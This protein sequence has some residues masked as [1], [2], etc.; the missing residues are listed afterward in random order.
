VSIQK[1]LNYA[2]DSELVNH[3]LQLLAQRQRQLET[4][5]GQLSEAHQRVT[6]E[7][8][9]LKQ[10]AV[11][12]LPTPVSMSTTEARIG[13]FIVN[14]EGIATDTTTG[15][16]WCRF[17]LGQQW[18]NH[19]AQGNPQKMNWHEAMQQINLLNASATPCCGYSDWRLPTRSEMQPMIKGLGANQLK[20][21]FNDHVKRTCF[22]TATT[23]S[24]SLT[25]A[26]FVAINGF[27]AVCSKNRNNIAILLVR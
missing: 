4:D 8:Q 13:V 21:V 12:A 25:A 24:K 3:Y 14:N 7:L 23:P 5:F 18:Q 20:K 2:T 16:S 11:S 6:S 22:W 1:L 26:Y 10:T 17:A 15:L 27:A 9:H 19:T